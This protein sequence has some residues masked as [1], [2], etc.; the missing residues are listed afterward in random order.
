MP[1]LRARN[2]PSA[3]WWPGSTNYVPTR[4]SN[5]G[6]RGFACRACA[7]PTVNFAGFLYSR[8]PD[9]GYWENLHSCHCLYLDAAGFILQDGQYVW[10]ISEQRPVFL[11]YHQGHNF[12]QCTSRIDTND[13]VS[14]HISDLASMS[15]IRSLF[16]RWLGKSRARKCGTGYCWEIFLDW[17]SNLALRATCRDA[18]RP[19][20]SYLSESEGF[21][22]LPMCPVRSVL[23]LFSY[24]DMLDWDPSWAHEI[25]Y[26]SI[27]TEL[28]FA[29]TDAPQH[30]EPRGWQWATSLP[31]K[32]QGWVHPDIVLAPGT[33]SNRSSHGPDQ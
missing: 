14:L 16:K 31:L 28:I 32:E 26:L 7:W 18:P 2:Y 19:M 30:I 22:M 12:A 8:D 15:W 20:G 10:C 29:T 3:A 5:F 33:C 9:T 13:E 24:E 11:D 27:G 21:R 4:I 17:K 25:L 1:L 6:F 23:Q